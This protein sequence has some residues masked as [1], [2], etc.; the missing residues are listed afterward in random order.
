VEGGELVAAVLHLGGYTM[1]EPEGSTS[2][3]DLEQDQEQPAP[4]PAVEVLEEAPD[5]TVDDS[6]PAEGTEE[7]VEAGPTPPPEERELT[8]WQE[9]LLPLM[10]YMLLGLTV[11]FFLASLGQLIFL[12]RSIL[13]GTQIESQVVPD[14]LSLQVHDTAEEILAAGRLQALVALELNVLQRRY[15]Q[16]NVLLMSGVWVRYLGFVTGMTMALV[17]AT[18]ILGKL[19]EPPVELEARSVAAAFSFVGTSPGI[20]LVV[21]GLVLML[22]T[23]VSQQTYSV[24][25]RAI[26]LNLDGPCVEES[27]GG[28]STDESTPEPLRPWLEDLEAEQG[29]GPGE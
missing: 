17:G 27:M 25:D 15:H 2:T 28:V 29:P 14:L 3:R 18:F 8:A 12:H 24:D 4:P 9:K 6:P 7:V 20:L 11:F 23:I 26:F 21:V 13:R 19:R 22:T 16:A 5:E 10:T 1:A